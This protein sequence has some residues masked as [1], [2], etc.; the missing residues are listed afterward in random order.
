MKLT[1]YPMI[2]LKMK[3]KLFTDYA[4]PFRSNDLY[5]KKRPRTEVVYERFNNTLNLGHNEKNPERENV[6]LS[7]VSMQKE[8]KSSI[9]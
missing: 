8:T 7:F 9:E 3:N 5:I 4:L 1:S 2:V 6:L